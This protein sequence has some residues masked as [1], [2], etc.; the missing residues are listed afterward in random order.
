MTDYWCELAWLGGPAATAG[1]V[2]R[3]EAGRFTAVTPSVASPPPGAERLGGLTLPVLANAHSHAFHRALRGRTQTGSG[4]FWTWREQMYR[5]AA[6]LTPERYHRVARAVFAEMALAGYGVV[7]EFHYVHHQPDGTPYSDP[8]AM[9]DALVQAARDAGVR[10]TLLDALYQHGGLDGSGYRALADEQRRF[11]DRDVDA[12]VQR[13]DALASSASET[14][15]VG[16]AAH[17]VRAVDPDGLHAVAQWSAAHGTPLHVHLSEQPAENEQCR[18]AHGCSPTELLDAH[19]VLAAECVAVHA[20]HVDD[21]DVARLGAARA[22]ICACPTTERDLAD[23]IGPFGRLRAAGCRLAIGSDSHAVIDGFEETRAIELDERLATGRRGTFAVDALLAAATVDG[24]A[25]I[26]WP[27]TGRLEA[28]A[29]ADLVTVS[30][31]SVR[32]AGADAASV[33]ASAAYA[34]T[35]SDVAHVV[36]GGET[37]V[38]DGAHCRIDATRELASVIPELMDA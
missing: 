27:D 9:A 20:T 31:D 8:N 29:L 5:A 37:V 17:S 21:H 16:V 24:C 28:G 22:V 26:A 36:I 19:G 34:A 30:L 14:V 12:W 35:A 2:L 4:S 6:R 10:I 33:L 3:I 32:L 18:A 38:R 25:A 23:G 1:V 13:V 7:G 11:G 15:R